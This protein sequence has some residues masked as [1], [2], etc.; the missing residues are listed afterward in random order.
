MTVD[1]MM[2][3]ADVRA[4]FADH[5]REL[6]KRPSTFGIGTEDDARN[7]VRDLHDKFDIADPALMAQ[8]IRSLCV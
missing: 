3:D 8:A 4:A 7:I 5:A 1:E 6:V 2:A